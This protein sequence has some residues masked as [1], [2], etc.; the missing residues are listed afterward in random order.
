MLQKLIHVIY[1]NCLNNELNEP[2]NIFFTYFEMSPYK[3]ASL[4]QVHKAILKSGKKVA[5]KIQR[6]DRR[7]K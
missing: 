2:I 6:P 4:G 7:H 3:S 5:V 1:K